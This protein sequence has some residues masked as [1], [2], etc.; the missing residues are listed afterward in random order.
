MKGNKAFFLLFGTLLSVPGL[1]GG[2]TSPEPTVESGAND[3]HA[4]MLQKAQELAASG[5][6]LALLVASRLALPTELSAQPHPSSVPR[7]SDAWLEQAIREGSEQPVIARAAVSRCISAGQCDIPLAIRILKT[8][9][10][11]EAIAQLLLWR[12]AVALG[13][14]EEASLAWTRATQA[15]RFVDEYAEGLDMLDRMTRGMRIPVHSTAVQTDP[16]Q[17]RLIM[18]YAL[19]SAFSMTAL[20]EVQQQCPAPVD[21]T[22]SEGCRN[23]LTL[24]AGS[25]ALLASS[26]GSARMQVYARDATER[27]YWQQRR[28]EVAWI[29]GQALGLLSHQA[30]GGTVAEMQQY[31]RWNV[32]SGELG[33]MRQLLAANDIPP[34]P[35]L[36]WQPEKVL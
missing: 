36:N 20:G 15:T 22:R 10:A 3:F 18:V 7:Q 1:A 17:A 9:E 27:E 33:A 31:L 5:Q 12:M 2:S 13:D 21:A 35:P 29:S 28:R 8:Q 34:T 30:D 4:P 23:L 19:A 16:E 14:T 6:P 26:Y 11:D 32:V 25:N 24:L